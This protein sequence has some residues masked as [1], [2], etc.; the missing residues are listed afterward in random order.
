MNDIIERCKA[1]IKT[2]RDYILYHE[3]DENY[4][5]R[6]NYMKDIQSWIASSVNIIFITVTK[7]SYF[8]QECNKIVNDEN[9]R[10]GIPLH[11][12]Q[13]LTGLLESLKDEIESGFLR[14]LEY[15]FTASAFD[16]FLDHAI[17]F[18]KSGKKI[19][20]SVLASV[21]F[22]DTIRKI[23]KKNL[24]DEAGNNLELI[25][26]NLVKKNVFTPIKAKRIKSYSAIRN[27]ALHAQW[28]EFDLSDIGQLNKGTKNI[29]ET[30]L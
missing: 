22:E 12:V 14:Q 7:D 26:D 23:A 17:Q 1:L 2:G 19:E 28:D 9:L 8:Y 27:Q 20:S 24:V 18:H 10:T 16:D 30:F 25:I 5:C 4:W 13:K 29:I 21:V 15:I 11:T 6:A 3:R